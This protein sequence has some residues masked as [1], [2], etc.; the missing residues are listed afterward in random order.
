MMIL[1]AALLILGLILGIY[2]MWVVGL[3][4]LVIGALWWF[5]SIGSS[6]RVHSRY[7]YW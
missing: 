5:M 7:R 2:V 4:L 6:P 3:I 1:G